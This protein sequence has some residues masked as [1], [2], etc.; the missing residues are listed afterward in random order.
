AKG[1]FLHPPAK[2]WVRLNKRSST[3]TRNQF[4]K[5]PDGNGFHPGFF[6]LIIQGK[7]TFIP[8]VNKFEFSLLVF[9]FVYFKFIYGFDQW[10]KFGKSI[11]TGVKIELF[12]LNN[13]TY[14]Y[15]KCPTFL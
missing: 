4:K 8:Y 10:G 13:V 9:S 7:S 12:F 2:K 5:N 11:V 6:W 15:L 14:L 1:A 3:R